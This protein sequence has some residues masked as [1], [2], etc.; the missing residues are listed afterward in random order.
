MK[1]DSMLVVSNFKQDAG[2]EHMVQKFI[3][4]FA[5]NHRISLYAAFLKGECFKKSAKACESV[6]KLPSGRARYFTQILIFWLVIVIKRPSK[7]VVF[8]YQL[9]MPYGV[10]LSLVPKLLRPPS[11]LVHHLPVAWIE[12][13]KE[14]SRMTQSFKHF[15]L[16]ITPSSALAKEL[17]KAISS[18]AEGAV[19]VV[20]NGIDIQGIQ[21]KSEAQSEDAMRDKSIRWCC[22]YVGALRPDKRVDRLLYCFS[23]LPEQK[24][25]KLVFVGDGSARLSLENL[26]KDLGVSQACKFVGHQQNP[27][28]FVKQADILVQASDW[29]TFGLSLLEAM[30]L[31]IPVL[32][33][34]D[35]SEGLQDVLQDGVQGRLIVSGSEKE[36][37]SAWSDLFQ[38]THKRKTMA[39]EGLKQAMNFSEHRML[40]QYGDIICKI[41]K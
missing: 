5:S 13:V 33:M 3:S 8:N 27:Y 7:V 41:C 29:E 25:V 16:H 17:V 10:A 24:D 12:D 38:D 40:K 22:V 4:Y 19:K 26:A 34:G 37:V 2:T 23:Q 35:N 39:L 21:K 36:F 32:A 30:S 28:P 31:G 18:V 14:R 15:N 11:F 6:V 1:N 20:P 9:G